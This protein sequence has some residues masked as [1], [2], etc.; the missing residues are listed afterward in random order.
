L[1]N[2]ADDAQAYNAFENT[3]QGY[4]AYNPYDAAHTANGEA[5]FANAPTGY[6]G[7]AAHPKNEQVFDDHA[8]MG[9]ATPTGFSD[10]DH[11]PSANAFSGGDDAAFEAAQDTQSS[12]GS[13]SGD[14]S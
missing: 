3:Q 5:P 2:Y 1:T 11:G 7:D 10:A 14:E 9:N 8:E 6:S 4:D 13:D 12:G